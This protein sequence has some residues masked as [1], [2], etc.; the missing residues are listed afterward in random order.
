MKQRIDIFQTKKD[1]G[2]YERIYKIHNRIKAHIFFRFFFFFRF[3][4]F[5]FFIVHIIN[6]HFF[7]A[8]KLIQEILRFCEVWRVVVNERKRGGIAYVRRAVYLLPYHVF[9]YKPEPAAV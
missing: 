1:K 6:I 8:N 2:Y 5:I 4:A 9:W 3:Y 7:L